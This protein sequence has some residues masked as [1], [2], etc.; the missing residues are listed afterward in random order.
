MIDLVQLLIP[1]QFTIEEVKGIRELETWT[2]AHKRE[3]KL[4]A[5][6]WASTQHAI[7]TT[8]GLQLKF[9][10]Q[11]VLGELN[12]YGSSNLQEIVKDIAPRLLVEAGLSNPAFL[13]AIE[14]GTYQV[15]GVHIAYQFQVWD[16]SVY[17][18]IEKLFERMARAYKMSCVFR[19]HGFEIKQKSRHL[20][21]MFYDAAHK[22]MKEMAK[23]VRR[24]AKLGVTEPAL[25]S[26]EK[27]L[28]IGEV[29]RLMK[30]REHHR[31]A[32]S[33]P[34]LEMRF[35]PDY[36][37]KSKLQFGSDWQPGTAEDLYQE[38][39]K[40][41]DF[42]KKVLVTLGRVRAKALLPPAVF[43]TFLLWSHGEDIKELGISKSTMD[44]HRSTIKA[45]MAIDIFKSAKSTLGKRRTIDC[46]ALFNWENR[47]LPFADVDDVD[48]S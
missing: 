4:K 27:L 41:L 38:Y 45:E 1:H 30:E 13:S 32:E 15:R 37:R 3:L 11:H 20:A 44:R 7:V 31:L 25:P 33:G 18:V 5:E 23:E 26:M 2:P 39:L 48:E 10:P 16:C 17:D 14:Q 28:S 22:F 47:A 29:F 36:F 21:Y 12:A 24:K 43:Q 40:K 19:G 35:G 42:P 6:G 8:K 46:H 9:C 34:R